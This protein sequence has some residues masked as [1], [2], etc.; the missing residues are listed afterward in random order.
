MK[1]LFMALSLTAAFGLMACGDDSSS[2]ATNKAGDGTVEKCDVSRDGDN[3]LV[4]LVANGI[5]MNTTLSIGADG[6]ITEVAKFEGDFS[7]ADFDK[8][9]AEQKADSENISVECDAS[10]NTITG[11]YKDEAVDDVD[12]LEAE[13]TSMCNMVMNPEEFAK[14]FEESLEQL[15]DAEEE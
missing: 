9:C 4:K 5:T 14:E 1:K 2:S 3:V 10:A 7:Q 8:E 12:D 11:T 13:N 15:E 6:V